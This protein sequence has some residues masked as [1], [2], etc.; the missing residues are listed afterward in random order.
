MDR[1]AAQMWVGDVS[2]NPQDF[3]ITCDGAAATILNHIAKPFGRGGFADQAPGDLLLSRLEG[4]DDLWC[5]V[6]EGALF[7]TGDEKGDRA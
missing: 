4:F 7:I 6:D 3:Q 5:A 1:V 2:L